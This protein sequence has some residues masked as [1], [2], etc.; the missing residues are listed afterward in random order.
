MSATQKTQIDHL[1]AHLEGGRTITP[2]EAFGLYGMFRLAARI[3]ELRDLGWDISTEIRHDP[4][5]KVYA[6]YSYN[7]ADDRADWREGLELN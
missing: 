7:P 6:V 3:K 1:K 5:G 4:N 2:L